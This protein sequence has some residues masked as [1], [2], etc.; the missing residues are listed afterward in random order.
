MIDKENAK[1][2][3]IRIKE[4]G[5]K[6]QQKKQ[7][8]IKQIKKLL[9]R[10]IDSDNNLNVKTLEGLVNVSGKT[11]KTK[12]YELTF[13]GK[14]YADYLADLSTKYELKTERKQSKDF[15]STSNVVIRGDNIEALKILYQN[16][17]GK[18]KMIYIDPPYNLENDEFIYKDNFKVS[19][20]DL[21]EDFHMDE[22]DIEFL[23]NI[24][25]TRAHSGWLAFMYPRLK[26]ARD[27]LSEDG[28]IFISIDDG[29]HAG[30]KI[31]CDEI[32]GEASFVANITRKQSS[33]S[34]NDTGPDKIISSTDYILCYSKKEFSFSPILKKNDKTYKHSDEK[35]AF[36]PRPLE[37]QGGGDTLPDRVNLGY[38]IYHNKATKDVKVKFDYDINR[39]DV[40]DAPDPK[41][42]KKGYICY[43]P[44]KRGTQLGRWRWG[45]ETFLKR[46]S[47]GEV[48]FNGERVSSKDRP[49]EFLEKY[50]N[51][52]LLDFINTQGTTRLKELFDGDTMFT[53][54]KPVNLIKHLLISTTEEDDIVLDFFAGSGT[55]GDAVMQLNAEDGGE[56]RFILVQLDEKLHSKKNKEA[57]NFCTKNKLEPVISSI[58]IE[59]L[60]RAGEKIKQEI[61]GENG[62]KGDLIRDGHQELPD[63]G[64]KVYSLEEKPEILE[65][66]GI[67]KASKVR[68][69]EDTLINMMCVTLKGLD[70]PVEEIKKDKIYMAGGEVY[71]IDVV[72]LQDLRGIDDIESLKINL[73]GWANI[74]LDSMFSLSQA[75]KE[76]LTVVY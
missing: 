74:D 16:Y 11:S 18:V 10:V 50:P 53:F 75:F 70:T 69:T 40:Y 55:T 56:R 25:G 71:V 32:F 20:K 57:Y 28:V 48:F 22:E 43:R 26:L 3:S 24:Y 21:I 63:T 29:E 17:F 61:R 12:G 59:R 23:T 38:S 72:A 45:P 42:I 65:D 54:P 47:D 46:Y 37:K 34:K 13:A 52:L 67:F 35:G 51:S 31:M 66:G 62:K 2:H 36:S 73:N 7:E 39:E 27:L 1:K 15:D 19:D 49:S 30:L 58:T 41:L 44:K 9:P 14:E 6:H 68:N 8:L 76:N 60:N 4:S 64:Y 33:G 5:E